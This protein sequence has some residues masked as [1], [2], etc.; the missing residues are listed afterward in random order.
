MSELKR[1]YATGFYSSYKAM[2]VRPV[3]LC[4]DVD[5]QTQELA[6]LVRRLCLSMPNQSKD[7]VVQ[8]R[9]YLSRKGFN[10]DV[11][12]DKGEK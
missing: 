11:L 5:T 3:Y 1:Y 10:G 6:M 2:G 8:A 12:R 9:D 7:I 4:S